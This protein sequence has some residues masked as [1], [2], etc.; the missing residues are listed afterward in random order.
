MKNASPSL[1]ASILWL[2]AALPCAAGLHYKA[3]TRIHDPAGKSSE[4]QVEGWVSGEKARV[5][6]VDTTGVA[7]P[8]AKKGGYLLTQDGGRNL[9]LVDPEEKTYAKWSVDGMLAML[10][11][12][13]NG[14]GPLLKIQFG[15]P[16][17]E[18]LVDEDGGEVAGQRTRHVQYRTRYAMKVR[19]LGI[20]SSSDVVTD[21][22]LWLASKWRDP[23]LGVWLRAD[24]PR[25]GNGEFDRLVAAAREK[26]A[27]VPL[28]AVTVS[29]TI[30]SKGRR[31]SV[32]RTTTEATE[33]KS[34]SVPDSTFEIP[35]GYSEVQPPGPRAE[36]EED[37]GGLG[38]LFKKPK[39]EVGR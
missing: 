37:G 23:G 39:P 38:S 21:E 9:Y 14:F 6:F 18:K 12:L 7:V 34:A 10:G 2:A 20:S 19:V 35:T 24:S 17:V 11:G 29:T 36:G 15:P 4:A 30:Q 25:T 1:F 8:F 3:S 22:D 33:I 13:M 32:T 26:V 16:K 28:K 5:E 31:Q 27:G